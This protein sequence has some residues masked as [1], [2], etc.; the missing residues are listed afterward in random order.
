M[1]KKEGHSEY[2]GCSSTKISGIF[3]ALLIASIRVGC[4]LSS[5]HGGTGACATC[6]HVHSEYIKT[7]EGGGCL[8]S[9]LELFS[10]G[11]LILRGM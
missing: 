6:P 4:L 3:F 10:P 1:C 5:R 9:S 7:D 11:T 2:E 8:L